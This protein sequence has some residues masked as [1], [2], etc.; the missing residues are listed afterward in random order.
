MHNVRWVLLG[1]ILLSMAAHAG[2][3]PLSPEEILSRVSAAWQG[4]RFHGVISL[5]ITT[6][7][8]TTSRKLEIW[9]WGDALALVRILEPVEDANS[10][11]LL[12][13][14][15][16]WYY[17]PGIGAIPLPSVALGDALFGAGPS[18]NDL[19]RGTLSEDFDV[20]AEATETGYFLRLIPHEASSVVIGRLELWA[21][22]AFILQQMHTFDQ[23]DGLLQT[24]IF[25]DVIE[26]EDRKLATTLLIED[27]W[28]GR[29]VQR[30][31]W[32]EFDV[33][34]DAS[35]FHL[36]TFRAWEESG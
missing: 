18:L 29:T 7:G 27:A 35:F 22:D 36:E 4:D 26:Y 1:A 2:T 5:E 10:G 15:E 23:R 31:E 24:V 34:L 9:T 30:I 14:D 21:D 12:R 13:D 16:M 11:Y 19:S 20:N 6:G 28:G 8:Q 33:D 25:T 32:A 3:E 17:A